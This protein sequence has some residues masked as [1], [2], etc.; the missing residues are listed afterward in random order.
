MD[1]EDNEVKLILN[2]EVVNDFEIIELFDI[3]LFIGEFNFKYLNYLIDLVD[4]IYL[5]DFNYDVGMNS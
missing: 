4:Y 2:V 3:D 5:L 1:D